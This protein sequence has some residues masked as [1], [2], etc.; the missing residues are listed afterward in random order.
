MSKQCF[1]VTFGFYSGRGGVNV[2]GTDY[3]YASSAD[4]AITKANAMRSRHESVLSVDYL[5]TPSHVEDLDL[6]DYQS[7]DVV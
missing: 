3:V 5:G 6:L 4:V 2:T 1:Q 7:I